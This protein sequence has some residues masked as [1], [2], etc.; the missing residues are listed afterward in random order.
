MT[1]HKEYRSL[2]VLGG[3][4]I[5]ASET[6]LHDVRVIS[7]IQRRSGFLLRGLADAG[8]RLALVCSRA[9]SPRT[10]LRQQTHILTMAAKHRDS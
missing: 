1:C 9:L 6:G 4:S 2:G 8:G 5:E 7:E 10:E 3:F